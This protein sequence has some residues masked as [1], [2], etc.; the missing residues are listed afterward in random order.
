MWKTL[1]KNRLLIIINPQKLLPFVFLSF[2]PSFLL[3]FSAS[4]RLGVLA[5]NIFLSALANCNQA[6]IALLYMAVRNHRLR[7]WIQIS[8][9][10]QFPL[11]SYGNLLHFACTSRS[12]SDGRVSIFSMK[13]CAN[14]AGFFTA[15][16]KE[17]KNIE[18]RVSRK[19]AATQRKRKD[20]WK[21]I[22]E[23]S[24]LSAVRHLQNKANLLTQSP[25]ACH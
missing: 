11:N 2:F 4:W 24:C 7:T 19:D 6:C 20:A 12:G 8:A 18:K 25:S 9:K 10:D 5:W 23:N 16:K 13:C 22:R 15:K 3:S 1:F 21:L 14:V 17:V